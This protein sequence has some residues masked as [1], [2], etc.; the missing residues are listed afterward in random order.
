MD[1]VPWQV[2][3]VDVRISPSGNFHLLVY[4]ENVKATA[5]LLGKR[6]LVLGEDDTVVPINGM[7]IRTQVSTC[8]CVHVSVLYCLKLVPRYAYQVRQRFCS[9]LVERVNGIFVGW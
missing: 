7:K 6:C 9:R 4:G 3:N 5:M 8:S 1:R 2:E